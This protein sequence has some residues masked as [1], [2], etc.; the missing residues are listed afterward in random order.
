MGSSIRRS[1]ASLEHLTSDELE[2]LL[3]KRANIGAVERAE[4][5]LLFCEQC[6]DAP[7]KTEIDLA[8][9][10]RVLSPK[11]CMRAILEKFYAADTAVTIPQP[12]PE[13]DDISKHSFGR[14]APSLFPRKSL[15]VLQHRNT[16]QQRARIG[17]RETE[18]SS[19]PLPTPHVLPNCH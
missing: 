19:T 5:H 16:P 15:S 3:M 8:A 1:S 12:T 13:R 14:K 11:S 4:R 9:L 18:P 10:R 7:I 6:E 17:R 2:A